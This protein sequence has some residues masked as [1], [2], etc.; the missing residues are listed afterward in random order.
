MDLKFGKFKGRSIEDV[1]KTDEG[2]GYLEWLK[3][4]TKIEGKFAESNRSLI[5]EID[6]CLAG[7]TRYIPDKSQAP[8]GKF[9]PSKSLE[10]CKRIEAKVDL[11]IKSMGL[12]V[13]IEKPKEDDG[14][15]PF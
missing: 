8:K 2:I 7:K 4:E 3:G 5:A 10:I 1:A 6:R 11:I 14:D 12:N 13:P 15:T 9:P